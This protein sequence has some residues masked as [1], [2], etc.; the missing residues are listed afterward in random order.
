[1][2]RW[3]DGTMRTLD[4]ACMPYDRVR[5]LEDGQV[6]ID[7]YELNFRDMPIGGIHSA[8]FDSVELAIGEVSPA[9]LAT[10][11]DQGNKKYVGLPI[12]LS[13]AFRHSGFFV[14]AEG[15][16]R[17][18]EDLRGRK[19]GVSDWLGTTAIW[20]RGILQD[21]HDI[22]L[23]DITWVI[24][25]VEEGGAAKQPPDVVS[26][27]FKFESQNAGS[28][29]SS[30]MLRGE[31]DAI[32][33]LRPPKMFQSGKKM[34]RLFDDYVAVEQD[35]YSRTC[36]F[37]I[38]HIAVLRQ[39]DIDADTTL[40][41]RVFNAFE[42]AKN[43]ALDKLGETAFYF[44]SLPWLPEFVETQRQVLGDDYWKYGMDD[45]GPVIATFLRYC[46]EQKI[47]RREIS[48]NEFFPCSD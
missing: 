40:P 45:G 27:S 20:Q 1:M 16:I 3:N 19:I 18:P 22:D 14:A 10:A 13:R 43:R 46:H 15:N 6:S 33:A 31:L 41:L 4:I 32:L 48:L 12:Y 21:E 42:E 25:P 29:L 44:A 47:T 38:M 30:M 39:T 8:C 23:S 35:Y 28:D 5:A 9:N 36:C 11:L 17:Q 24:E 7:G 26:S 34:K 2:E 37:P